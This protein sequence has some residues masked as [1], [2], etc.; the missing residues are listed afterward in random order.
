MK[1]MVLSNIEWADT[2][3]FGNTVSNWFYGIEE[4]EFSTIY[5]RTSMPNN[6]VC[7]DYYRI[8]LKDILKNFIKKGNIGVHFT[9]E[10]GQNKSY[11]TH[12]QKPTLEKR[13]I[14]FMHKY[15]V[16]FL[17]A[18]ED[19]FFAP[20]K[21]NNKKFLDY[22]KTYNPDILFSF[23][24][25]SKTSLLFQQKIKAICPKCKVVGHIADDVYGVAKKKG[26]K[27]IQAQ[28]E[29]ADLLYGASEKLCDVYQE[30]FQKTIKPLYKGCNFTKVD[31]QENSTIQMIYAGNLLYGRGETL[32]VLAKSLDEHNR[33]SDKKIELHIYTG[34]EVKDSLAKR[35]NLQGSSQIHQAIS[36]DEVKTIMAKA[37]I[38]LHVESFEA[39][40]KEVIKY[41]FSTK[42]IDCLQSG[43]VLLAIGPKDIASIEYASGIPGSFVITNMNEIESFPQKLIN[44]DLSERAKKTNEYARKYHSIDLVQ[45]KIKKDFENLIS[46]NEDIGK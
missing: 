5:R 42:I 44:E 34:T 32:A 46:S 3:A 33:N 15:N 35:L 20:C 10:L 31:K 29:N 1:I 27:Y 36:Y 37:D 4:M 22:V 13:L 14:A 21:W 43:T 8:S 45:A 12:K 41:S 2:N 26:R 38:S 25:A 40:Q 19:A 39:T 6:K 30:R 28:I 11:S 23:I 18:I 9:V 16:G 17:G 7:Q 24:M